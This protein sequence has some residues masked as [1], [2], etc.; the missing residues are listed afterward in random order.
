MKFVNAIT[1]KIQ[2]FNKK[3]KKKLTYI[4][5]VCTNWLSNVEYF[6]RFESPVISS[7]DKIKYVW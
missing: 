7:L 1:S 5:N 2:D 4:N 6:W 3:K